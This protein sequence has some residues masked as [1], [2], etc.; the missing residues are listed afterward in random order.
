MFGPVVDEIVNEQKLGLVGKASEIAMDIASVPASTR[1][2]RAGLRETGAKV[3]Q[4]ETNMQNTKLV[5]GSMLLVECFLEIVQI[6]N[7]M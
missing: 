4:L 3:K 7:C 5:V 1:Y 6:V 2:M